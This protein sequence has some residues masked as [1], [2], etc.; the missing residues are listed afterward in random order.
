MIYGHG[1]PAERLIAIDAQT[2]TTTKIV[3]SVAQN[4]TDDGRTPP[5]AV[6]IFSV[7]CAR[8]VVMTDSPARK[9][10]N[11][12][13]TPKHAVMINVDASGNVR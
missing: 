9:N 10:T 11:A 12:M 2:A 3:A 4:T 13:K 1:T 7:R 6:M 5:M 8:I